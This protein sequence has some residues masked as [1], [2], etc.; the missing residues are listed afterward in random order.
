MAESTRIRRAATVGTVHS[1]RYRAP[2]GRPPFPRPVLSFPCVAD[3][4]WSPRLL[5]RRPR[6]L[7]GPPLWRS[8][9]LYP[10]YDEMCS[11]FYKR[12]WV[13]TRR[14]GGRVRGTNA[15]YP[16]APLVFAT[17]D[18]ACAWIMRQPR[19]PR[20]KRWREVR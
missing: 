10:E 7:L 18:E 11:M 3:L 4:A 9:G 17:R 12:G 15:V 16:Y 20:W 19:L 13:I 6:R 1:G 5:P 8:H 14:E 2:F